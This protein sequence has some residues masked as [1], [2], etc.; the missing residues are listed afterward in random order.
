[1]VGSIPG[2]QYR[3]KV[4]CIV[5]VACSMPWGHLRSERLCPPPGDCY[6][7]SFARPRVVFAP[8]APTRSPTSSRRR[9]S[10]VTALPK[11]GQSARTRGAPLVSSIDPPARPTALTV[12]TASATSTITARSLETALARATT[13]SSSTSSSPSRS[14]SRRSYSAVC[15]SPAASPEPSTG[16]RAASTRSPV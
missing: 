1:M 3:A 16:R 5:G 15:C 9:R 8:S 4:F 13:R 12:T 14:R 6:G 10:S 11:T 7:L 2:R